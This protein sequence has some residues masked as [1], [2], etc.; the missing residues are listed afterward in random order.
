M[1]AVV[2]ADRAPEAKNAHVMGESQNSK[3][4]KKRTNRDRNGQKSE[5]SEYNGKQWSKVLEVV[6][7]KCAPHWGEKH[8]FEKYDAQ[9]ELEHKNYESGVL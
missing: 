3:G 9:S 7:R 2:A 8:F 4:L 1:Y 6:F 5:K